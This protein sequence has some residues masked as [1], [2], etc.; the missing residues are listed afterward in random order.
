MKWRIELEGDKINLDYAYNY[1]TSEDVLVTK[2]ENK[3]FLESKQFNG[4]E[5]A[6]EIKRLA[7]NILEIFNGALWLYNNANQQIKI[8]AVV[9]IDES[10]K[11]HNYLF[12]GTLVGKVRFSGSVKITKVDK[13]GNVIEE[14]DTENSNP[15]SNAV[16]M[17]LT[18]K[19]I[20]DVMTLLSINPIDWSTLYKIFE[21]VVNDL[22]RLNQI[23]ESFNITRSKLRLFKR[24]ANHQDAVGIKNSRHAAI[25]TEPPSKNME[26]VEA[27]NLIKALASNWII[28]KNKQ[29][30]SI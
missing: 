6:S 9:S 16:S 1:L 8:K 3:Y 23:P 29:K 22:G 20:R 25:K 27:E 11:K 13:H 15:F 24:T 18:D 28:F 21:I 10:G 7:D 12:P 5:D 14:M 26:K 30:L 19:N 17:S 4:I 2:N